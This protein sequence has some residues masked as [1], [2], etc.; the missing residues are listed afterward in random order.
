VTLGKI[1]YVSV[2]CYV[3]KDG[4]SWRAVANV[5]RESE[6]PSDAPVT[7]RPRPSSARS[8]ATRPRRSR[9]LST[10]RGSGAGRE[11]GSTRDR[12]EE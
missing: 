2:R 3:Q 7:R 12:C 10:G 8:R 5:E 1:K 6:D 4:E 9:T 11:R